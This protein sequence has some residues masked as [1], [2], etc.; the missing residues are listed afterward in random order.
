MCTFPHP[1]GVA[2]DSTNL[3]LSHR[4]TL[5]VNDGLGI[6]PRVRATI[7]Y[8]YTHNTPGYSFSFL[9]REI[10][11]FFTVFFSESLERPGVKNSTADPGP[12]ID[13]APYIFAL[14]MGVIVQRKTPSRCRSL[15]GD[16]MYSSIPNR[17]MPQVTAS[18]LLTFDEFL[19]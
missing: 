1:Q 18:R 10:A 7:H 13:Y 8:P 2:I 3:T 16:H 12:K 19:T 5:P 9:S 4:Q 14:S 15:H 17:Y 11:V 6:A